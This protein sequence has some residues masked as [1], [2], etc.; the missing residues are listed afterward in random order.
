M[1][2][3]KKNPLKRD[4]SLNDATSGQ[5]GEE[6]SSLAES[7]EGRENRVTRKS[8]AGIVRKSNR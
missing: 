5:M 8:S 3:S 4:Q 2:I 6:P 1:S 7:S